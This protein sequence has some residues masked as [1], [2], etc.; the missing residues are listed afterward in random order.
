MPA[1]PPE[2]FPALF[3]EDQDLI[4]PSLGE[5]FGLDQRLLEERGAD[6]RIRIV[7]DQQ[8]LVEADRLARPGVQLLDIQNVSR[9]DS[10]LLTA[11]SNDRKHVLFP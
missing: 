3:L 1:G 7:V 6:Q 9:L 10:V 8:N 4:V 2:L 5:D 11:R